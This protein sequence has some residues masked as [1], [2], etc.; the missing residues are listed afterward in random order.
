VSGPAPRDPDIVARVATVFYALLAGAGLLWI[1]LRTGDWLPASVGGGDGWASLGAGAALA[2]ATVA[3][4][5]PLLR[6]AGWM[7][8]LAGEMRELLGPIGGRGAAHLAIVSGV[9]EELFFRGAMQPAVGFVTTSLVF[10]L[11]HTGPDRRYLAWTAFAVVLGFAL[12]GILEWTGS[13]AGPMVAH[14]AVNYVNLRRIGRMEP[15]SAD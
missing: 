1:R 9:G 5:G 15:E 13:L 11:I 6:A 14:V 4:S 3:V 10:G 7:R 8:W 12:G 2:A